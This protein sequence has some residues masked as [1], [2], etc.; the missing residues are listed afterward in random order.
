MITFQTWNPVGEWDRIVNRALRGTAAN[1]D[2]WRGWAPPCDLI[3]SENEVRLFLDLPGVKKEDLDIQLKNARTLVVQGDRKTPDVDREKNRVHRKERIS[4]QFV[5]AFALP[6]D[7]GSAT[8]SASFRDGV[9]EVVLRKP[10]AL[11]PRRIEI[12]TEN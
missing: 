9:L 10:E 12:S 8:I 3:E 5:R 2:E 4:G 1:A 7:V 11:K 6:F